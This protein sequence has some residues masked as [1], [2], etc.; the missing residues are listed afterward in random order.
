MK[1]S[2]ANVPAN[3]L[4]V[5]LADRT[6]DP[7]RLPKYTQGPLTATPDAVARG[8]ETPGADARPNRTQSH[9][10]AAVLFDEALKAAHIETGEAAYLLGVSESLVRRMRSKDA[11][12]RVSFVQLLCLPPAFHLELHRAMNRHYGFGRHLLARVLEDLGALALAGGA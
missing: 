11:R 1:S 8:N 5:P 6:R 4:A 10:L 7:A 12:E 2:S 9:E 3:D